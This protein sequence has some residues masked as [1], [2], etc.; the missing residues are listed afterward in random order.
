LKAWAQQLRQSLPRR[1][2]SLG[3]VFMTPHYFTA[4]ARIL[5]VLR[6]HAEIPL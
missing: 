4:A 1:M 5:E 2:F 6:V 3:L